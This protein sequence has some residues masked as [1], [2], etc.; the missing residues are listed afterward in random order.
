M[1]NSDDF[2]GGLIVIVIAIAIVCVIIYLTVILASIIAAVAGA[3][4]TLWGGG[5]ALINY[6]KSFKENTID[7][8]IAT[9]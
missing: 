5:T 6:A 9:A 7:S 1:N 2:V 8:N 4:G 3:A